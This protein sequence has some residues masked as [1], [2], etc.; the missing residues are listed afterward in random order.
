MIINHVN[1]HLIFF[2]H[3]LSNLLGWNCRAVDPKHILNPSNLRI[4]SC[5]YKR[6]AKVKP[7]S[8]SSFKSRVVYMWHCFAQEGFQR[9]VIIFPIYFID[10]YFQKIFARRV[11]HLG[12]MCHYFALN[13]SKKAITVAVTLTLNR[14][15]NN[16]RTKR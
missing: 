15:H 16:S 1:G 7:I 10:K 3:F 12:L 14:S 9:K 4:L 6:L 13:E 8:W 5:L 11:L 2:T